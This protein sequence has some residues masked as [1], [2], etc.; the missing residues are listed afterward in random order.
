MHR[1]QKLCSQ[2]DLHSICIQFKSWN[3]LQSTCSLPSKVCDVPLSRQ[4]TYLHIA[5][6]H[7]HQASSC[8]E[9]SAVGSS[10]SGKR[11]DDA[12][13]GDSKLASW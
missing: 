2:Y 5:G 7:T 3:S 6:A 11:T 13:L 10:S 8:L 4:H 12:T 9:K 1:I